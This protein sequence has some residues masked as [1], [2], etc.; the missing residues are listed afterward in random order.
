MLT[1]AP[2]GDLFGCQ[3]CGHLL[4]LHNPD[5]VCDCRNCERIN[6]PTGLKPEK[7][8]VKIGSL[9]FVGRRVDCFLAFGPTS[10]IEI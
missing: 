5:F 1:L 6:L 10:K 7:Q 8:S 3:S 4:W 9:R 2:V